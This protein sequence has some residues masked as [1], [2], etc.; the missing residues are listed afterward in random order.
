VPLVASDGLCVT[1]RAHKK[2]VRCLGG[3]CRPPQAQVTAMPAGS[4]AR[5]GAGTGPTSG[6]TAAR[7]C[8]AGTPRA[9]A[10]AH[11]ATSACVLARPNS[12]ACGQR[13]AASGQGVSATAS[14][15]P[16]R[17]PLSGAIA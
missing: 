12:T 9:S 14:A 7:P 8:R 10:S 4:A 15:A 3:T 6:S 13:V 16:T 5:T 2:T 17:L 11:A 1:W